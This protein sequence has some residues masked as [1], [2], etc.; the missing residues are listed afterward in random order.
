MLKS[1]QI[2]LLSLIGLQSF[3]QQGVL[4]SDVL[5]QGIGRRPASGE[6]AL[7]SEKEQQVLFEPKQFKSINQSI[8]E[9]EHQVVFIGKMAPEGLNIYEIP[10][11]G[12]YQKSAVQ[13]EEDRLFLENCDKNFESRDKASRFF[14]D[15]GWQYLSEGSK[16]MSTY[17]FNLA[18]LLDENNIDAFWG[19]GVIEY[20]QGKYEDA[21]KLMSQGIQRDSKFNVSLMVDLATVHLACYL[22]NSH[23][24]DLQKANKLLSD[25]T[26]LA[27][28]FANAYFQMSKMHLLENKID[29][30]WSDFH[31]GYSLKPSDLD[32]GLL[33]QLLEK[34]ADPK[35]L[36]K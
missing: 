15:M 33:S 3:G 35:G 21:I 6:V 2:G 32:T 27:P 23:S 19:L 22:E 34:Q 25:A 17:R 16:E 13:L 20:Q 28:N 14:S 30:A 9:T 11:F 26:L 8:I 31:K 36:F 12:D 24:I 5:G 18:Y 1:V 7:D 10:L 4:K 29:E